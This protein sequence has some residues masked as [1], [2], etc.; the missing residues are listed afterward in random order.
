M[1]ERNA[2]RTLTR[3]AVVLLAEDDAGDIEL[4]RRSLERADVRV[5][6]RVTRDGAETLEYLCRR[7]RYAEIEASPRPD[8]VLLDLN[9]PKVDGREVLRQIRAESMLRA[10]PVVVLTT[11]DREAD[12]LQS[13]GL[14]A[15]S[16]ITKP[17]EIA[18]FT[19][20]LQS[21]AKYWLEIV[22]LP[23]AE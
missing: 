14:G 5:D 10:M 9:M 12:I 11:S 20:V 6:V 7:G 3:R 16:Y 21:L 15:N 1:V 13:Y 23:S 22:V 19:H 8:L 4:T 2:P 18:K 17:P